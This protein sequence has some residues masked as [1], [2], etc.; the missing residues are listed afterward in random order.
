[1][2]PAIKGIIENYVPYGVI[3]EE[4]F[5]VKGAAL[6]PK[7]QFIQ[8]TFWYQ[9]IQFLNQLDMQK[10]QMDMQAKQMQA[11]AQ[12]QAQQP[13][14]GGGDQASKE[15]AGDDQAQKGDQSGKQSYPVSEVSSKDISFNDVMGGL[16]A[17]SK[18]FHKSEAEVEA[19]RQLLKKLFK[20]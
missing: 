3:L 2:N 5:G 7:Y 17:I 1:M 9:W 18:E 13:A 4:V 8:N 15:E 12:Q 10:Q 20:E 6:D 16:E 14:P 11:E 19:T